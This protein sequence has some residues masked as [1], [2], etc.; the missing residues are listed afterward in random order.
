MNEKDYKKVEMTK[1][2]MT[3]S[4]VAQM[5]VG[6]LKEI[7]EISGGNH[8]IDTMDEDYQKLIKWEQSAQDDLKTMLKAL[9]IRTEDNNETN[10]ERGA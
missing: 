2:L 5:L 6:M 4:I 1:M 8:S 9:K 3:L 10:S 7:Q